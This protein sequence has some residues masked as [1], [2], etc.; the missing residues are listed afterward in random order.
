MD[1]IPQFPSLRL[2]ISAGAPLIRQG[3]GMFS[4][5]FGQKIHTFYGSSECGG[6]AYG[7]DG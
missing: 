1:N 6:I 4:V 3:A 2:C 7:R 5:K